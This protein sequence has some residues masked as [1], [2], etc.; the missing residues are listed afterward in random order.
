MSVYFSHSHIHKAFPKQTHD[1]TAYF[2][3]NG[4]EIYAVGGAVRDAILNREVH[5]VDFTTNALP[6]DIMRL[7]TRTIL[8]GLQHGTVTV[9]WKG[10]RFEITTYRTDGHYSNFRQPESVSFT[11]SLNCD[12]ARRDFTINALALN[13]MTGDLYD[14]YNGHA[15]ITNKIIRCVGTPR[16]RFTE[17]ALRMMRCVRFATTLVFDIEK[18]T[19][20]AIRECAQLI[21]H[22]S[23]ER[24]AQE[25]QKILCA[26]HAE[27]GYALLQKT[28][29]YRFLFSSCG[30]DEEKHGIL[31]SG[32]DPTPDDTMALLRALSTLPLVC[33]E[34]M[35]EVLTH[36]ALFLPKSVT[37]RCSYAHAAEN[38]HEAYTTLKL[39]KKVIS[40]IVMLLRSNGI[41]P[42]GKRHGCYK[43]RLRL[44]VTLIGKEHA[45]DLIVFHMMQESAWADSLH[46]QQLV[47]CAEYLVHCITLQNFL[48]QTP[49]TVRI[50][51]SAIAQYLHKKPGKWLGNIKK[52][53]MRFVSVYPEKNDTRILL[54]YV[55]RMKI[56]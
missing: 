23:R 43:R 8:T 39:S 9:L 21:T 14:P 16:N 49:A 42:Y 34:Q 41:N 4:Y 6:K 30:G 51:G 35:I 56:S 33:D 40:R 28:R 44:L 36:A 26:S 45:Y 2:H 55:K 29:L 10:E 24:I 38:A 18:H 7:C 27:R 20:D 52:T 53:L 47:D 1:V 11:T 3:R 17:D 12:L 15:D 22:I 31:H 13:L 48:I 25:L 50:D 5:D 37:I 19:F 32:S 54:E 46:M